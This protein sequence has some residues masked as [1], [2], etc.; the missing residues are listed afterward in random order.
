MCMQREDF[1]NDSSFVVDSSNRKLVIAV[2]VSVASLIAF[3]VL[4]VCFILWR[5]RKVRGKNSSYFGISLICQLYFHFCFL[6]P[7]FV[8][9]SLQAKF[10]VQRMKLRC[11]SMI[12]LRL[13]LPQIIFLF[14]IR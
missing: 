5:R 3:L 7:N 10:K 1:N 12:L 6:S 8:M 4:V 9:G 14:P 13:R 11:H 2:S